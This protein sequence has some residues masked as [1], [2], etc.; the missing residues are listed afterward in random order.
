[1]WGE[2]SGGA[3]RARATTAAARGAAAKVAFN[4]AAT[5]RIWLELR[6][7]IEG[8]R[9][10]ASRDASQK[11]DGWVRACASGVAYTEQV[12]KYPTS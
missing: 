2:L 7:R 3:Q 10:F 8:T 1:V 9:W 4:C 12:S 5:A 11:Y 6:A